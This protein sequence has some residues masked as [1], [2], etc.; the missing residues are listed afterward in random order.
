MSATHNK[1]AHIVKIPEWFQLLYKDYN[2]GELNKQEKST[3]QTTGD[4]ASVLMIKYAS[5]FK[6][7]IA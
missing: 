6:S 3:G 1:V 5:R 7:A 2:L 4:N